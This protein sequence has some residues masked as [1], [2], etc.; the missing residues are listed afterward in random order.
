MMVRSKVLLPTPFLPRIARLRFSPTASE[1][2]SST[3]ASPYPA[4][5]SR[6]SSMSAKV[7]LSHPRIAPD[8]VG[9]ACEQDA[10]PDHYYYAAREAEHDVHVV[11]DEKDG[12]LA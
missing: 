6:S 2:P 4:R 5:T 10:T 9:R 11:L 8:L 7:D 1:I 12:E 3:T